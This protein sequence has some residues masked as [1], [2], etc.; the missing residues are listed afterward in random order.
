[1]FVPLLPVM[2]TLSIQ[3]LLAEH[4]DISDD[5]GF[6]MLSIGFFYVFTWALVPLSHQIFS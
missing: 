5:G 4:V 3:Y 1:M 6:S 2:A